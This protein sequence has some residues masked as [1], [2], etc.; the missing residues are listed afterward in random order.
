M[1]GVLKLV[2]HR[3]FQVCV[4]V[5]AVTSAGM[6]MVKYVVE[7]R[8]YNEARKQWDSAGE[9]VVVL[10]Q[11]A[12][13]LTSLNASPFPIKLETFLRIAGIKYVSDYKYP[14]SCDKNKSPWITING[15]DMSDSQLALEFLTKKF[16]KDLSGHLSPKE[17]AVSRAFRVLLEDHFYW[18][19]MVDRYVDNE[20]RHMKQFFG[21]MSQEG[22]LSQ[23]LFEKW[24]RAAVA[25]MS[26]QCHMQGMSRHG[27]GDLQRMGIEDLQTL[28]TFLGTKL[29]MMGGDSPTELDCVVF[30]FMC[31]ILHTSK[32]DSIYKTLVEK[33]LTNLF[34]HTKRMKSKFYPDWEEVVG[35]EKNVD[36][37]DE[38]SGSDT[39]VGKETKQDNKSPLKDSNEAKEVV[40]SVQP[41][42]KPPPPQTAAMTAANSSPAKPAPPANVVSKAPTI[43][44]NPVNPVPAKQTVLAKPVPVKPIISAPAKP[45][46][47]VNPAPV[48]PAPPVNPAPAAKAAVNNVQPAKPQAKPSPSTNSKM[49]NFGISFKKR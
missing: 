19:L 10:H 18:I 23:H 15:Q 21:W 11:F 17:K 46:A 12:R 28:S 47:P 25:K 44:A 8:R 42:N 9:D 22:A 26:T 14:Y 41:P 7:K 38:Q 1:D 27:K 3:G 16:N 49:P 29:F 35:E 5:V 45:A 2:S 6:V 33:R 4:G 43:P 39:E 34:Q 37:E 32:D 48:K 36:N 30:G 40:K 24:R 20:A 31:V 13:P